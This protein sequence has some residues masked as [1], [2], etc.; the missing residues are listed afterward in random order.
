MRTFTP[1]RAAALAA[2]FLAGTLGTATPAS[3]ATVHARTVHF[4]AFQWDSPGRDTTT[5]ASR[6][7]EWLDI[8]NNTGRTVNLRGWKV[9]G[10]DSRWDYTFGTYLVR[11]GKTVRLHSGPGRNSGSNGTGLGHVYWNS[12]TH[13]WSNVSAQPALHRPEDPFFLK[14]CRAGTFWKTRSP[15]SCHEY[16]SS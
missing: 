12:R 4:G 14:T 10:S 9:R 13:V 16:R 2:T 15:H 3:A 6:N 11:P 8:H 5:V 7:G 1:G